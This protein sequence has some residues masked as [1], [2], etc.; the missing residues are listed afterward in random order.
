MQ[1][2]RSFP[3]KAE[4]ACMLCSSKYIFETIEVRIFGYDLQFL[5]ISR[6]CRSF[7]SFMLTVIEEGVIAAYYYLYVYFYEPVY[8]RG[9]L[10]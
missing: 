6:L 10:K 3:R 1:Q 9:K 5:I 4:T 8:E 2:K 7:V